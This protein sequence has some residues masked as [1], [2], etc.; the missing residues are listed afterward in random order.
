[1][2]AL[3]SLLRR[4]WP[5]AFV[6]ALRRAGRPHP[7]APRH[8]RQLPGAP[9]DRRATRLVAGLLW[10]ASG[11]AAGFVAVVGWSG[12]T[13]WLGLS[14]GLALAALAAAAGI[15]AGRLVPQ[16]QREMEVPEHVHPQAEEDVATL[17][18]EGV[19]GLSR[20]SLLVAAGGAG[21]TLGAA[22]VV[23]LTSLGPSVGNTLRRSPWRPGVRLV[24]ERG[25]PLRP[26]QVNVGGFATAF[27]EGADRRALASSVVVIR[28]QPS[29]LA[30]PAQREGWAPDGLMA[31]SKICTHAGCA[32]SLFRYPLDPATSSGPALVCPCHYSTFDV[33]TGGVPVFGPAV[34]SLPQLPLAVRGGVLVAAGGFSGQVGPSWWGVRE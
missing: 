17:V 6:L 27:A 20:R 15:A 3:L 4:L 21:V 7:D 33:T 10:L 11:A 18:E 5:V 24:D 29:E 2:S 19:E 13:Q 23:P 25:R 14:C 28:L 31:F 16:Q 34:R 1:V 12:D 32:I 26:D 8:R 22:L 9:A 30:L